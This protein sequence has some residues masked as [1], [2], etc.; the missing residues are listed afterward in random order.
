MSLTAI[1]R[2]N[3]SETEDVDLVGITSMEDIELV[4]LCQKG[5]TD[6]FDRLFYKY[7][8]KIYRTAFRMINNPEDALDLTQEIFL[9]AYKNISKYN[10]KSE[11]STWL[12]RLA[13]NLC[14]DELRKRKNS[15]E[16][17][18]DS[19]PENLIYSDTPEDIILSEEQESLIWKALNSLKEKERVV[20]VL[21]E[22][23]GLSYE[24]IAN[25]LKCSMGRVK[26]RIHES[27][28]KFRKALEKVSNSRNDQEGG[29]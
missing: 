20:I 10:F 19:I 4:G 25:V 13:I 12:Y 9:K 14:I 22:M 2:N 26:S 29:R 18:M 8:D 3:I 17:L 7:R 21:R 23:E 1:I 16:V 6:A 5:D 28:E 11:F 15:N 24:E 27:R